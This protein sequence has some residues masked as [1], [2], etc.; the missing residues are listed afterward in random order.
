MLI[1]E[2]HVEFDLQEDRVASQDRPDFLDNERDSYFNRSIRKWTKDRYG[3][4]N[5]LKFGFETN[6][7]R[8]SNLMSLHIKFPVQPQLTPINRGNG[9]YEIQLDSLAYPYLFLTSAKVTITKDNCTSTIDHTA[10][11]I[12]DRKNLYNEPNFNWGRV[13][14]NFGRSSST[15]TNGSNNGELYSIYFDTTDTCGVQQFEITGIQLNY[16]KTP[17][18]VCRGTYRHIDDT[19]TTPATAN[20][21]IVHCDIPSEF[22]DEI[23]HMA[24]KL[25]FKDIQDQFGFQSSHRLTEEDK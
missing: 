18:R 5:R 9:I 11:Q 17:N 4:N 6:Q 8:I 21:P 13:H 15:T 25:A 14:A 2:M 7:E 20:S 24:V 12:D 16:I 19:T 10:W 3:T 23:V 1:D 22:H